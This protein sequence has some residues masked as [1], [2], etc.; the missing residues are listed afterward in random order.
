MREIILRYN[1]NLRWPDKTRDEDLW[2]QAGQE[3]VA[4]QILRKKWGWIGHSQETGSQLHTSN[5]DP[6]PA[7]QEEERKVPQQLEEMREQG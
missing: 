5:R 2:E 7:G 3:P 1:I 6:E 4:K